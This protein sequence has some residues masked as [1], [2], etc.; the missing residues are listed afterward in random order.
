MLLCVCVIFSSCSLTKYVPEG[1]RL[2]NREYVKSDIPEFKDLDLNPYLAQKPNPGIFGKY[3]LQLRVYNMSGADTSKWRNRIFRKMG[4][5]PV[6]YE[7]NAVLLSMKRLKQYASNCGYLNASVSVDSVMKK[8]RM[9]LTYTIN[10]GEPYRL[11]NMEFDIKDDSIRKFVY[12]DT[13]NFPV[14]RG[15]LFDANKLETGRQTVI[16]NIRN[17]GFYYLDK[18][19]LFLEADSVHGEHLIDVVL[20]SRPSL[21]TQSDGTVEVVPQSRLK[22]RNVN[23]FPWYDQQRTFK[24]QRNDS[25]DY[26]GF[27]F[28]YSGQKRHLSLKLLADKI[29]IIPGDYYSEN[30]IKKTYQMLNRLSTSKYVS[31][32]FRDLED[33]T[34][35]CFILL[36]PLKKQSFSVEVEGTNTDGDAGAAVNGTYMHRDLFHGAEQLSWKVRGAYQ[37]MGDVSDLL[38][39]RSLDVGTEVAFSVPKVV[40]PFLPSEMRKRIVA[41][42]EITAAY[43]YQTN[44]WY[45]RTITTAGLKYVWSTGV[46]NTEN[47]SINLLDLSFVYLPNI[48]QEFKDYYLNTASVLRYSYEDHFIMSTGF[49]FS[50]TTKRQNRSHYNY[51]SYSGGV[52]TAGNLLSLIS[53]VTNASKT[54]DGSYKAF[55]I[56]YSQYAKGELEY[57]FNQVLSPKNKLV[58]HTHFGVAYPYGNADVVP[59]EKRFFAGGANS[60]RG[61]SIR[62]LGPGIYKGNGS[63][64][65]FLQMGDIKVDFN[66]E[67]RFKLFWLFEGAMFVDGGNVW[68]INDYTSQPGG[69]FQVD[70]FYEQIAYSYGL[71][72]RFDFS[73]F[74]LRLDMGVKL[75]DPSATDGNYWQKPNSSDNY[76]FHL[77]VGYPF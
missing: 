72:L 56:K 15:D 76:A 10:G 63:R 47:Y 42:T 44:P 20:K 30:K 64:T 11:R 70:K 54:D 60:V 43:N 31:I 66:F 14:K 73:F 77:A 50:R 13:I 17:E 75:Y 51:F 18:D 38:S 39:D 34:L 57:T 52:E 35:D 58:Y 46:Q 55:N 3:R 40:V 5:A 37:P 48:S 1:S 22:I 6:I 36:S 45:D 2:L 62:S 67:Y 41:S 25:V 71:G 49:S 4:E 26:K 33:G 32:F 8:K 23:I 28:Y 53:S 21:R 68:T 65:D 69:F 29:F 19:N 27:C 16:D 9:N 24:E 7:P 61:W 59:F 12:R 74:I